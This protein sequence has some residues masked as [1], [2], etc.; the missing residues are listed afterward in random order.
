[1]ATHFRKFFAGLMGLALLSGGNALAQQIKRPQLQVKPVETEITPPAELQL[2]ARPNAVILKPGSSSDILKALT[3]KRR[4]SVVDLRTRPIVT[5]GPAQVDMSPVFDNPD[6]LIS[7]A[8]RLRAQPGLV[9]VEADKTDILEVTEG[10]IIRQY[11]SYQIKTGVCSDTTRRMTLAQSGVTCF[12]RTTDTQRSAAF[13]DPNNPRYVASPAGRSKALADARD[14]AEKDRADIATGIAEFR[15]MM[16]DPARRK[17]AEDELGASEAARLSLLS[18]DELEAEIINSAVIQV[19]EVMFIPAADELYATPPSQMHFQIPPMTIPEK[20]DVEKKLPD[21]VYL[22]GFTLGREI[23]WW[24]RYS[25]TIKTCVVGCKRTYYLQADA[26]FSYGLGLRFPIK[27]GGLYAYHAVGDDESAS[28]APVFEPINANAS[29]YEAAGI[30]S[31]QNFDGKEFVAELRAWAG[32]TYKVPFHKGSVSYDLAGADLTEDLPDPFKYGQFTPPRPGASN[33]VGFVQVFDDVDLLLGL[34]NYGFIGVKVT[35]ALKID[36][37]SDGLS[38][39]LTDNGGNTEKIMTSSG[40]TYSLKVLGGD[41]ASSFTIGYPKYDLAAKLT[42]G[43]NGR[44]WVDVSVWEHHWDVPVWFPQIA[45]TLP[46]DGITFSCHSGTICSRSYR[47][48][49]SVTEEQI[50]DISP[51]DNPRLKEV[52]TWQN[53][54]LNRWQNQCPYLPLRFCEV[55]IDG[56]AKRTAPQMEEALMELSSYPSQDSAAIMI[57]KGIAADNEARAIIKGSKIA[58]VDY[59]GKELIKLYEPVWSKDCA[60][61]LCRTRIHAMTEDYHQALIDRQI[62]KPSLTREQVVFEE[63]IQG[64]WSGKAEKEVQASK[65]RAEGLKQRLN[66]NRQSI[67]PR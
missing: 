8:S 50:E 46:P 23:E 67:K 6:S 28:I 36:L 1:M 3:V 64:D 35:P 32:V 47:Y 40:T 25:I 22:T 11:L 16:K 45:V 13:A 21:H 4:Y 37:V 42:P 27:V 10:L 66:I 34:V 14:I 39:K 58:A 26:G 53:R 41:H 31:D 30:S 12:S 48:S 38:L 57:T 2:L 19:E 62:A 7:L 65:A 44:F 33:A 54:Y 56:V 20:V 9:R 43:L 60:D 15:T 29:Q 52:W 24:K 63:N 5:L 49:P 51:P 55:A 17:E 18:N 59:Y 61:E